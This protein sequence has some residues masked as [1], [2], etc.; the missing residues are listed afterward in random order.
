MPLIRIQNGPLQGQEIEVGTDVV[1]LGRD[2]TCAIQILDKGASRNHAEVFRIGE[3]CFIRDLQSRNGTYVNEERIDEEL[4][5]D[6]DLIQIGATVLEFESGEK[7]ERQGQKVEFSED[8]VSST[9]ELRLE[10]LSGLGT[11]EGDGTEAVRLRAI[12]RLGRMI[13]EAH[14]ED[15][16]CDAVLP[17]VADVLH[18]DLAYLFTR[19]PVKGTITPLGI[20]SPRGRSGQKVSR[21]IIRRAIQDKRALLTNDA[22]SDGRFSA[23]ESILIK[24]IHSVICVPLSVS[25][26]LSGVLYLSSDSPA[27]IFS[28]EELELAAAMADQIGL[29]LAHLR[30]QREQ[31]E[32]LMNT[33]GMLVRISEMRN[34]L[35]RGHSERVAGYA[36]AV[37]RRLKLS[38][39][40]LEHLQL[41]ALLHNL[42]TLVDVEDT[43]Q[44]G[45]GDAPG[46]A[47]QLE[48]T[49]EMIRGMRCPTPVEAM[50]RH[51][52]ERVDGSGPLGLARPDIPLEAQILGLAIEFDHRMPGQASPSAS[53]RFR[54]TV[55]EVGKLA[56]GRF[57]ETVVKALLV[58]HR[59]G[60]L[61][62][63][64]EVEA[65][66]GMADAGVDEPRPAGGGTGASTP[67]RQA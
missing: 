9:L 31:R 7:Q 47:R 42:G 60:S 30:A 41:A 67:E 55:V 51:Q 13:G 26:G 53:A 48:L 20:H 50:I 25:G 40:Q 49:L 44:A 46:I 15:A 64:A 62:P 27:S 32:Q 52:Y 34:P 21:S 65:E 6:G 3:M 66:N 10:D 43:Q 37:G 16:L 11:V 58:A 33:I 38:K 59:D 4:L 61:V 17:F 19:D 63:A 23:Q 57:D 39:E 22:M 1:G 18:A 14:T 24:E 54:D 8:E 29:A 35:R 2:A 36:V 5:R 56:G 28:D 45:S 12:Y